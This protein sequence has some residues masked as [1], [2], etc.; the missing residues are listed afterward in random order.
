MGQ[1]G[2][3]AQPLQQSAMP[4][5]GHGPALLRI[6]REVPPAKQPAY[7]Q[8]LKELNQEARGCPGLLSVQVIRPPRGGKTYVIMMIFDSPES[9]GQ[10][11][12]SRLRKAFTE[13]LEQM[14]LTPVEGEKLSGLESWF[15]PP[16]TPLPKPRRW[17]MALIF[18]V[19]V[20]TMVMIFNPLFAWLL[21]E[22]TPY[23]LRFLVSISL[24]VFL[25]TYLII[26]RLNRSCSKWLY[27][28]SGGS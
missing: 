20:Y 28:E 10:F 21:P 25:M 11:Q 19:L 13:R 4:E 8:W 27:P 24:Q 26:P 5:T 14:S 23:Y 18:I 12:T 3:N 7:E 16:S 22:G 2:E 17:L 9:A 15:T 6:Q 1:T